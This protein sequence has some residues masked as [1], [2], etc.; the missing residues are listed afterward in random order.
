MLTLRTRNRSC[1]R[2]AGSADADFGTGAALHQHRYTAASPLAATPTDYSHR[3]ACPRVAPV[4][5]WSLAHADPV[6]WLPQPTSGQAGRR[7]Y[8][9]RAPGARAITILNRGAGLWTFQL[10]MAVYALNQ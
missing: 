3:V 6:G 1:S 5:S 8:R 4:F 9:A 2:M 10:H 7:A